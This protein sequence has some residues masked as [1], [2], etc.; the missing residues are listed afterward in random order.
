MIPANYDC[1]EGRNL[2]ACV[3]SAREVSGVSQREEE[4]QHK[5]RTYL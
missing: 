1:Q 2:L 3:V 4:R 5:S